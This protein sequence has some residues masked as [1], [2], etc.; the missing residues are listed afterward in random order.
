MGSG[1][2]PHD[3]RTRGDV[4]H[5]HRARTHDGVLPDGHSRQDPSADR[6]EGIRSDHHLAPENGTG[7][8][9]GIV[10][11][12]TVMV[13]GRR[14]VD[15]HTHADLSAGVHHSS[16]GD[17]G[18]G[19]DVGGPR[20]HR[21]ATDRIDQAQP[22]RMGLGCHA[23]PRR[24]VA[25]GD[26]HP[27][28]S[29]LGGDRREV[30]GATQDR[31]GQ[32]V[33]PRTVGADATDH[34]EPDVV[35]QG[36]EADA[37]VPTRSRH[38]HPIAHCATVT[39]R[40]CRT[41]DLTAGSGDDSARGRMTG[42]GQAVGGTVRARRQVGA[43]AIVVA[44]A[45]VVAVASVVVSTSARSVTAAPPST[46]SYVP[47]DP[48]ITTDSFVYPPGGSATVTITGFG[49][50]PSV[51]IVVP[52]TTITITV[53]P[54][55][56]GSFTIELPLP[57]EPGTYDIIA[58]CP[59]TGETVQTSITVEGTT[60]IPTDPPETDPPGTDPSGSTVAPSTTSGAGLPSTGS[61]PGRSIA[62]GVVLL[63]AGATFVLVT[64][65]RRRPMIATGHEQ[66]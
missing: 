39:L 65:V 3:D 60:P 13:D 54:D 22:R 11:D 36:V 4:A 46:T 37:C 15:D 42:T 16:S 34:V 5:D 51:T 50:C 21:V 17:H 20:D 27:G 6:D 2:N 59:T 19:T 8:D 63:V 32:S 1:G 10:V 26:E 56:D 48:Q 45:V 52:G 40:Y 44:V 41:G 57:E 24:V 7:S 9:V 49:G 62:V 33:D 38:D 12:A 43:L 61:D 29:V 58:T 28:T 18:A 53:V 30:V 64:R 35:E 66:G 47:G 55:A 25:D 31:D 23:A 14:R